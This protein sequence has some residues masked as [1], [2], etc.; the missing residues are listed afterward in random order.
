M[1]FKTYSTAKLWPLEHLT[2]HLWLLILQV[3]LA[4]RLTA[5]SVVTESV[6]LVAF[7]ESMAFQGLRG[8]PAGTATA[9][10]HSAS[11]PWWRRSDSERTLRQRAPA[12]S[13]G[14]GRSWTKNIS[15][16]KELFKTTF[17]VMLTWM[18]SLKTVQPAFAICFYLIFS[19]SVL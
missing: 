6:D 10:L 14:G 3:N 8:P 12:M 19:I 18:P 11:L 15:R 7:L 5:Q 1:G 2:S 17:E 9:S 13:D 4:G 16:T